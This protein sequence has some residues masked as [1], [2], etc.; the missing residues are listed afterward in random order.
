MN[1]QENDPSVEQV[2]TIQSQEFNYEEKA[3]NLKGIDDALMFTVD[4]EP[5][6][7][8]AEE[9]R[10]LLWK[11]DL[12]L[13]PL[14]L[15]ACLLQYS[16]TQSY[17]VAAIFGL[18]KDLKLYTITS[19]FQLNLSKYQWSTSVA[20]LGSMFA[21]YPLLI[22][23]QFLPLG[24]FSSVMVLYS[25][26]LA[27]LFIV[28]KDFADITALRFFYGFQVVTTPVFI[29]ICGM[30][31]KTEEQPLRIGIWISGQAFGSIVGQGIDYGAVSVRGAFVQSPWKWIYVILGSVTMGFGLLMLWKFP[32]SPMKGAFLT[33]REQEIAVMRV[34]T[35]N[36]G[37]QTR[38]FK[39]QQF[40]EAFKDLQLYIIAFSAFTFAFANGA[41]GSFGALLVTS[42]GYSNEQALKWC[43]PASG[44]A[45]S[46]ML[47][48]GA[49][50]YRFHRYRIPLALAFVLP[51]IAGNIILWR[52]PRDKKV[53]LLGGLYISTTF[54]GAY[55]Q[56]LS[57]ISSNVAGHTK[58][59]TLNAAVFVFANIGGFCGPF[60]Y[61]GSEAEEGYP[62]GQI[63]VLCLMCISEALFIVLLVYYRWCNKKK[64][65]LVAQHPEVANDPAIGF[66]DL[67]D[68]ENL[69]FRY[70]C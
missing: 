59:T 23:A 27:M 31:W 4:R 49:L 25:G 46:S 53:A 22:V 10:R 28:C 35:N 61:P 44:V 1:K 40:L 43:M 65:A 38:K 60:A 26:L 9:E 14:M 36:T 67:T 69:M 58:K 16:D 47:L 15:L 30:W 2:D 68:K 20:N 37:M 41:L 42:F 48:S 24:K 19:D 51:T 32:D 55:V 56:Q 3:V 21:Q 57:L 18:I 45:V 66:R 64:V 52:S 33:E 70:S 50:G 54:Y 29:M 62:T 12:R 8:T 5:I 34:Q 13:I 6:T 17:G 63:T 39:K 7:W 11:I